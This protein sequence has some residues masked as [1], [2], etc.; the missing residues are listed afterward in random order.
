MFLTAIIYT[1]IK[2][3]FSL[4]P[5]PLNTNCLYFVHIAYICRLRVV[6]RAI[7]CFARDLWNKLFKGIFKC[8]IIK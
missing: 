6:S 7:L 4:L 3:F 1:F 8:A 2:K 5:S